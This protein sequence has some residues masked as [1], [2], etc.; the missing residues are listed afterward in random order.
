M[1]ANE[2]LLFEQK[3]VIIRTTKK[4]LLIWQQKRQHKIW[5]KTYFFLYLYKR[6][7]TKPC[8]VNRKFDT[9]RIEKFEQFQCK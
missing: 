3:T 6:E 7:S 1:V 9:V 5:S 4:P 8:K 2:S